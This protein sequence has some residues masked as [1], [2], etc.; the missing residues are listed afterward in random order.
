MCDSFPVVK[1]NA[2]TDGHDYDTF[3]FRRAPVWV[4][5]VADSLNRVTKRQGESNRQGKGAT[6]ASTIPTMLRVDGRSAAATAGRAEQD[7]TE[8]D[9]F[10]TLATER[11]PRLSWVVPLVRSGQA[12]SAF[13]VRVWRDDTDPRLP[14]ALPDALLVAGAGPVESSDPFTEL[15]TELAPDAAYLWTVRVRD[16]AG[17]W[18][19]WSAP[20]PFETGPWRYEDWSSQWV[21]HAALKTLRRSFRID[22]ATLRAR[23]HLTAQG[24]VRAS[25]NGVT[26]NPDASDPSRTDLSRALYRTYD[27]TDLVT[28]G[29]N[30][31]DLVLGSGEWKRSGLDP[32]V[33][34]EVVVHQADGTVVRAGTGDGMLAAESEVSVEEPFYLERHERVGSPLDFHPA[35]DARVLEPSALPSSAPSPASAQAPPRDVAP[36]PSPAVHRVAEH[37]VTLL[38]GTGESRVYDVGTNIAGRTRLRVTSMLPGETVIR[39]VH[40]EHLD[41]DGRLDTTNLTMPYD[42]GRVRQAV[43]YVVGGLLGDGLPGEGTVDAILEPWFCYHGFRYV[44]IFGLPA[45]A[46]VTL[47]AWSLHS[48]LESTSDLETDDAQ[49][50]ALVR[51]ARRTL[52]NNVHGIPEDCPTREQAGWTGDTAS[53]AEFDFSAFDMQSFFTKWLGDLRTS[54]QAD[55]GIPAISPDL[56]S[57]RIT[58]DPVWGAVLQR[59][60][61]GH[62]LHYGDARVVR[63]TLPA[64]R[65][66]VDYQLTLRTEDGVIG[67]SPISYGSDWLALVQT[68]PPLHHT[69]A[70]IDSL[71]SLA[72]LEEAIGETDAAAERLV[73]ADGLRTA[74]RSAFFDEQRDVFGNGTQAADAIGIESRILVGEEAERAAERIAG[75][76]LARGGRVTS[77][78]AT[79]RTV[80]R[81]LARSG[82]SQAVFDTLHQPAEPGIGAMIDH[83]PGTFWECWWIDP[84]NTGT[85]SLDHVGLGGPFAGWA[86][87]WLAGVRPTGAGWSTFIAAP[88]F[89]IGVDSLALSSR[90]VRGVVGLSYEVDE[91]DVSLTL[92]V[93]VGAQATLRLP[94]RGDELLGS[95]VHTRTIPVSAARAAHPSPPHPSPPSSLPPLPPLGEEPWT[96]PYRPAPS[97]DVVGE[98]DWATRSLAADTISGEQAERVETLVDGLRCMPVPHE[99]PTGPVALVR[100]RLGTPA[101]ATGEGAELTVLVRP[102]DHGETDGAG[103]GR[104]LPNARFVYA[105]LDLCLENPPRALESVITVHGADGTSVQNAG[106]LWPVGW[107]RVTVNVSDLAARTAIVSVEVGIRVRALGANETN[108]GSYDAA[109]E[110]PLAFHLGEV[111]YSTVPRT[112]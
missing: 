103:S 11:M 13:D 106:T 107:N 46:E 45:D 36:D 32:R 60:L 69:L 105:L 82:H 8:H 91:E 108:A 3:Q 68:P 35:T 31:L 16:E 30:T 70:T 101:E 73:A 87:Q 29:E 94:G 75:D 43:E 37:S 21:T 47:E 14:D 9:R 55:G 81:A 76:V 71:E 109:Q 54:Q 100:S 25:V 83:G 7:G 62:W 34:A 110:T 92:T 17:V 53:V 42:N 97:P 93:P 50:N 88:Q 48:D 4:R 24:L 86:W 26:V 77:G 33:L 1:R 12:Q 96:P 58:P 72:S 2:R 19:D 111:G 61:V 89:V 52:L 66:W 6:V 74:A 63:E 41:A 112:W 40:G 56:R 104:L 90:T 5:C 67:N 95:G 78:F 64:L 28:T 15:T 98:R 18:S 84:L 20:S 23:L 27:V 22:G 49:V 80:V 38:S 99:Q 44:E 59:V 102:G 39:V 65:R 57:P 10:V 85:G 79:T 51:V